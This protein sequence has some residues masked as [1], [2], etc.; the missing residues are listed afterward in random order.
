MKISVDYATYIAELLKMLSGFNPMW[1]GSSG[2]IEPVNRRIEHNAAQSN[3]IHLKP[4]RAGPKARKFRRPEIDKMIEMKVVEPDQ[5]KCAL[6]VVLSSKK[7]DKLRLC[8]DN[9]ELSSVTLRDVC[10]IPR[11]DE[12]ID[13]LWQGAKGTLIVV[14][15]SSR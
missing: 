4:Y 3:L 13:S 2:H 14:I 1:D 7:D 9:H 12:Y 11:M 15:G 5:T 10:L 8:V 6:P